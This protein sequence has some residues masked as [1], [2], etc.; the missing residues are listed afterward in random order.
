MCLISEP[1]TSVCPS[2]CTN[3]TRVKR[4]SLHFIFVS[5]TKI[6]W[7][8]QILFKTGQERNE[9]FIYRPT[10]VFRLDVTRRIANHPGNH[11]G[12]PHG[13]VITKLDTKPAY[14]SLTQLTLKSLTPF[15]K[16]KGQILATCH[17]CYAKHAFLN[18]FIFS[19]FFLYS[20]SPLF[21]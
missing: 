2:V 20:F 14:R 8:I 12:N 3:L 11:Y 1:R 9:H 19:L 15:A 16:V 6:L 18:S 7:Y 4:F 13:D 10:Y 17:N 21:S 5:F